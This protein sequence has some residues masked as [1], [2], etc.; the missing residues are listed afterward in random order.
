MKHVYL[1]YRESQSLQYGIGTYIAQLKTLLPSSWTLT[2]FIL[3]SDMPDLI[4]NWEG[5]RLRVMKIPA[6]ACRENDNLTEDCGR[7]LAY[8]LLRY[9]DVSENLVFHFNYVQDYTLLKYLKFLL[10]NAVMVLTLHCLSWGIL[11]RGD[12]NKLR[13][14][15]EQMDTSI[16]LDINEFK[17]CW[18][19]EKVMLNSVDKVIC[20]NRAVL[21][22]VNLEYGVSIDKLV[23]KPN[24]LRDVG[25]NCLK[26]M[27]VDFKFDEAEK[28]ILYVGRIEEYKGIDFVIEAFR[29]VLQQIENVR[30]VIVGDGDYHYC[31]RQC[32]DIC[33]KVTLTGRIEQEQLLKLYQIAE[34]GLL[35]SAMEQCSYVCIEMMMHSLP[36][37]V[38]DVMGLD[39]MVDENIN[40]FRIPMTNNAK[41]LVP[42]MDKLKKCMIQLLEN[43]ELRLELSVGSRRLFEKKYNADSVKDWYDY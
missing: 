38:T 22:F 8:I 13:I 3:F 9:V 10:P 15:Q 25:T 27:K 40:G 39:E 11:L 34:F 31:L 35:L 16:S 43:E 24:V 37:I 4:I 30:L 14:M 1:I 7:N 6:F 23:L 36:L 29:S 41:G 18:E 5:T 33:G 42:E 17:V 21:N 12:W 32:S 19:Q 28:I 20:L 26:G 2:L